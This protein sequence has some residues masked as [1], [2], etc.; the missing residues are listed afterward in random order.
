VPLSDH[1]DIP[2]CRKQGKRVKSH[3]TVLLAFDS[4]AET[5]PA[6]IMARWQYAQYLRRRGAKVLYINVPPAP[7]GSK[8]GIDDAIAPNP[9]LL[10]ELIAGTTPA[11]DA[12]PAVDVSAD[13]QLTETERLRARVDYLQR[14]NAALVLV[15]TNP[16]LTGSMRTLVLRTGTLALSKASRGEVEPNGRVRLSAADISGD[17]RPKPDDGESRLKTNADG[18]AFHM[19]RSSVKKVALDAREAGLLDFELVPVRKTRSNGRPY[20]DHDLLVRSPLSLAAFIE[21]AA[22]YAP[23]QPVL[24]KD[25]RHQEP[26]PSCG[27]VHAW[28]VSRQTVCGT[29]D[30]P[31]CGTII[32]DTVATRPVPP[33]DRP[34]MTDEED[35]ELDQ[36]TAAQPGATTVNRSTGQDIGTGTQNVPTINVE[37]EEDGLSIGTFFLPVRQRCSDGEQSRNDGT[38]TDRPDDHG[39]PWAST[40]ETGTPAMREPVTL[41]RFVPLPEGWEDERRAIYGALARGGG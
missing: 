37:G 25:Y 22:R 27:E 34:V 1:R 7:D 40:P 19:A 20:N 16:H 33:A 8:R 21:P 3:R 23:D 28:T 30:D 39:G 17:Y 29:L 24:R 15:S 31:G 41:R 38:L 11:P 10:L 36:R 14:E 2:W 26:C 4:D 9:G 35:A 5:N 6:V 18:T 13:T 12:C 32:R